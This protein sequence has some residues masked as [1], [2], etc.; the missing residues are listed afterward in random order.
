MGTLLFQNVVTP[1]CRQIPGHLSLSSLDGRA[2]LYLSE[3]VVDSLC[4]Y[5][6]T[7]KLKEEEFVS[8]YIMDR[9]EIQKFTELKEYL[10]I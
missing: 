5:D 10:Q 1:A 6:Y 7:V 9:K 4:F 2:G 8:N 3:D